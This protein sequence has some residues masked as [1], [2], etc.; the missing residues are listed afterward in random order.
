MNCI[1]RESDI[2]HVCEVNCR[3]VLVFAG[4]EKL[5]IREPILNKLTT[6]RI[7]PEVIRIKKKATKIYLHPRLIG[8]FFY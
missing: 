8:Y 2:N 5:G 1:I 4:Y 6:N 3:R 7:D